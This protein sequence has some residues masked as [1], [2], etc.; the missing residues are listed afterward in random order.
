[1]PAQLELLKQIAHGLAAQCGPNTEVVIHDLTDRESDPVVAYIENGHI[2]HRS[3]GDGPSPVG[4]AARKKT[5]SQLPDKLGFT[6]R[7]ADGKVLKSST[8]YIWGED[9][10]LDYI[11]SLNTD[12]TVLMAAENAIHTLISPDAEQQP[13]ADKPATNVNELLD[14]LIQQSVALVGKPVPLM[15]KEDKVKAIRF[16]NDSGALL[17]TKSGAKISQFFGISKYTLYSYIEEGSD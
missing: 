13:V 3:A 4:I 1:M 9:D 8:L 6:T 17:I 11:L 10:Q 12:V 15:T 7:T 2:T 16:L 5:R 14:S